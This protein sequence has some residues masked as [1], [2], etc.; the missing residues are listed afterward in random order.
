MKVNVKSSGFG[1]MAN[2]DA[3][4]ED[5]D[6]VA[7]DGDLMTRVKRNA[8]EEV[9][10]IFSSSLEELADWIEDRASKLDVV[11][12]DEEDDHDMDED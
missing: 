9:E 7:V 8:H 4:A 6:A 10:N 1:L 11:D 3:H 2:T 12:T 5:G